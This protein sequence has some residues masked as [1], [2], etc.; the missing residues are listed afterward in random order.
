[1]TLSSDVA[2]DDASESIWSSSSTEW[3]GDSDELFVEDSE[4]GQEERMVGTGEIDGEIG[5]SSSLAYQELEYDAD[6]EEA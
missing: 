2:R 6:E 3:F 4:Q 1:M 5:S